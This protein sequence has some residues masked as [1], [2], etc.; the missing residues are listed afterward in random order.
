MGKLSGIVIVWGLIL[1]KLAYATSPHYFVSVNNTESWCDYA[2]KVTLIKGELQNVADELGVFVKDSNGN[3][4]LIGSCV[5]GDIIADYYYIHIFGDDKTTTIKDGAYRNDVLYLK[6][7]DADE[8][9]EYSISSVNMTS[10]MYAGKITPQIPPVWIDGKNFGLLNMSVEP[11]NIS[12]YPG[13]IDQSGYIDLL[14]AI[15]TLQIFTGLKP[16]NI[17]YSYSAYNNDL[18]I[19][20][21]SIIYILNKIA[22]NN[23]K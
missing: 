4:I 6:M 23:S 8:K 7:W 20:I 14:D 10:E 11:D 19:K 22:Q 5:I 15:L 21:D 12:R 13:D 9:I 1:I 2:G 16:N 3:E 18:T 17:D